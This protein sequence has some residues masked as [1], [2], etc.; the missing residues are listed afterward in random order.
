MARCP[1]SRRATLAAV[2]ACLLWSAAFVFVKSALQFLPPFS[3]GGV[4]FLLAGLLLAPLALPF[5]HTTKWTKAALATV[6][7]S[8]VFQTFLQYGLFI[9]GMNLARGAQSAIIV[10]ASPLVAALLA[11]FLMA[12]DRLTSRKLA[13]IALGMAGV[14]LIS[15]GS[16]PWKAAGLHE[17]AGLALLFASTSASALGNIV[18]ARQKAP[19][20]PVALNAL[21]MF[22][23][24]A[25][26]IL[27]ALPTE[28]ARPLPT[29]PAFWGALVCL[30]VI[31]AAGF[32]IWFRLLRTV[33]VSDLNLWKFII[34]VVG[35][36]LSWAF[37]PGETPD[38][39]SLA[40]MGCVALAILFFFRRGG[41]RASP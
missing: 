37:L 16:K 20:H 38:A 30:A 14:V 4:R 39:F 27:L 29:A 1:M 23:G 22:L 10:G 2:V 6:A 8:A 12:G 35:A 18:I 21:Q 17:L 41:A 25:L 19:V 24:G 7:L 5:F 34:P 26:L 31:S 13:L 28:G 3:L 36:L 9:W 11:H 15:L 40:G 32:S 33:K